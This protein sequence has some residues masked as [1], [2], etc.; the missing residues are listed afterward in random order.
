MPLARATVALLLCAFFAS[1]AAR[2]NPLVHQR[3]L[4]GTCQGACEYYVACKGFEDPALTRACVAEC[5]EV[6]SDAESLRAFESL[7][8]DNVVLFVE[9]TTGR[10]PGTPLATPPAKTEVA[11]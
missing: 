10:P 7:S 3:R 4:T 9:G 8:C 6:F 11:R 5:D 2:P 1:C